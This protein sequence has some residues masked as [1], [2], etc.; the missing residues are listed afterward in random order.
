MR[1]LHDLSSEEVAK[2]P[3]W[4]RCAFFIQPFNSGGKKFTRQQWAR[5]A[6][7]HGHGSEQEMLAELDRL[8]AFL[9]SEQDRK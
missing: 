5:F 4:K 9:K 6:K 8:A 1:D 3:L 7:Y 2:F